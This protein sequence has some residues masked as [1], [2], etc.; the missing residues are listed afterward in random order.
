MALALNSA[1]CEG[2]REGFMKVETTTF[3]CVLSTAANAGCTAG[4]YF[5]PSF[6]VNLG[7]T[8]RCLPCQGQQEGVGNQSLVCANGQ[9][10]SERCRGGSTNIRCSPCAIG[11]ARNSNTALQN[12]IQACLKCTTG[13][14]AS[15]PGLS[16][17]VACSLRPPNVS[18]YSAWGIDQPATSDAACPW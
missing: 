7:G 16:A 14:F 5:Q 9:G 3:R 11:T 6:S 4:N 8:F 13:T 1:T 2:C 15:V 10:V 18:Q 12:E 17:C